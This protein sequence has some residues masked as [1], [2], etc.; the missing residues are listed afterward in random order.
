[1]MTAALCQSLTGMCTMS[2]LFHPSF[3]H[4]LARYLLPDDDAREK[5]VGE[6][7][8]GRLVRQAE[9]QAEVLELDERRYRD[10]MG[11][12]QSSFKEAIGDLQNVRAMPLE[13]SS[14]CMCAVQINLRCITCKDV[15]LRGHLICHKPGFWLCD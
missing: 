5:F 11:G 7:W 2:Q 12:E 3:L 13:Q 1:M 14:Y 9:R 15:C 6:S 10:E 8:A 4:V